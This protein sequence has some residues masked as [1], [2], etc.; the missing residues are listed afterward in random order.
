MTNLDREAREG[1]RREA[2]D[3]GNLEAHG[4]TE[5]NA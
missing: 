5:A 1:R 3:M 2:Q 4:P